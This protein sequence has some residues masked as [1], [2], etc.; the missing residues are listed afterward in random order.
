MSVCQEC[1]EPLTGRQT[2]YCGLDCQRDA[3]RWEWI[4]KTYGLTRDD[5]EEIYVFQ[6]GV[7]PICLRDFEAITGVPHID[8]E[9]GA[10]IRGLVCQY[11]NTRIIGRLKD[12]EM[13]QRLADYLREPPAV[14][15]LGRKVIAPG[16]KPR[17]RRRRKA[18][19]T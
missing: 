17:K 5:Y 7:C 14:V 12:H 11:C 6:G 16:R 18:R 15:S 4:E 9:H 1:G 13:A 10:H 3:R 19:K 8:H 2:K